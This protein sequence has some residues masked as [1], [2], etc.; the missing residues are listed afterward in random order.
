VGAG[1]LGRLCQ[2]PPHEACEPNALVDL[3]DAEP[4]TGQHGGDVDPLA[5]QA[6]QARH[7]S[8]NF[9][10]CGHC[11]TTRR[12]KALLWPRFTASDFP[13]CSCRVRVLSVFNPK[14]PK[15]NLAVS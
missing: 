11:V 10:W 8:R 1:P 12:S 15:L 14:C 6:N 9:I 2:E 4:L 3:L 13:I 7:Q 5:M